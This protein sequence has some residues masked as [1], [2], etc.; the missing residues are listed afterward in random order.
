[1]IHFIRVR[2]SKKYINPIHDTTIGVGGHMSRFGTSKYSKISATVNP[3]I[4]FFK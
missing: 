2:Y 3:N 1:M 4:F